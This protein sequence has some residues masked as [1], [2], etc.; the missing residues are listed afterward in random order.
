METRPTE[1]LDTGKRHPELNPLVTQFVVRPN[2]SVSWQANKVVLVSLAILSFSIAGLFAIQGLWPIL[3]FVGIEIA[4]LALVLYWCCLQST[5][6]E[7]ISIDADNIQ[8]EVGRDRALQT[9]RLPRAWTSVYLYPAATSGQRNRLVLRFKGKEFEIGACLTEVERQ[10]LATSI[11]HAL[12]RSA[13][14]LIL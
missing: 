1:G 5:R 9:Y 6:Y 10:D 3:P 14:K 13:N 4:L 8:I 2:R 12:E 7:V 11:R